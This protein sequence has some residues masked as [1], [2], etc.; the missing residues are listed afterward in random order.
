MHRRRR[1]SRDNYEVSRKSTEAE[2]TIKKGPQDEG[3]TRSGETVGGT[4]IVRP[5]RRG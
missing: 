4:L 1:E 5:A 3:L 2:P